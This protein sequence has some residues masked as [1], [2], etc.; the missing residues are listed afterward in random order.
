DEE[1]KVTLQGVMVAEQEGDLEVSAEDPPVRAGGEEVP[2]G[3]PQIPDTVSPQKENMED[4][5][6][7]A[8]LHEGD[9]AGHG[10]EEIGECFLEETFGRDEMVVGVEVSKGHH[11]EMHYGQ[12]ERMGILETETYDQVVVMLSNLNKM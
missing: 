10:R 12:E 7:A 1:E 11:R 8:D 2:E 4:A 3:L 9:L 5:R 6:E